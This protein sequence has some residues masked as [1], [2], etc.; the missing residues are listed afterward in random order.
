MYYS[1]MFWKNF[2]KEPAIRIRGRQRGGNSTRKS[3][4]ATRPPVFYPSTFHTFYPQTLQCS[5]SNLLE[6]VI[7]D[8]YGS[9]TFI[10][11]PLFAST[12]QARRPSRFIAMIDPSRL[13]TIEARPIGHALDAFR[14]S[15][16]SLPQEIDTS[17]HITVL[18]RIGNQGKCTGPLMILF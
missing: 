9:L 5:R 15:I 10:L 3:Y 11:R 16:Q 14:E 7:P 4:T 8:L 2:L 1:D 12:L 18:D 13:A 6:L 17:S